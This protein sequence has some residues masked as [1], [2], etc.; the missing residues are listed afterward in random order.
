MLGWLL[1]TG[2]YTSLLRVVA[3]VVT[4]GFVA[5]MSHWMPAADFGLLAM[6][7][8][9]CTLAAAVGAF[10]QPQLIVRDASSFIADGDLEQGHQI[11]R[12]ALWRSMI[13][14]LPVGVAVMLFF[15]VYSGQIGFAIAAGLV[16]IGLAQLL[17]WAAVARSHEKYLWSLGPKD[18]FWRLGILGL[19]GV[20]VLTG[21]VPDIGIVS[22]FAVMVLLLLLG[23]QR[24]VFKLGQTQAVDQRQKHTLWGTSAA[25][26]TSNLSNVA[27]NT[28]DVVLVGVFLTE[29]AA[30]QYFPANRLALLAGFFVLP[31]TMVISPRFARQAKVNNFDAMQRLNSM[32]TLFVTTGAMIVTGILL[33]LYDIYAPLFATAG[34]D[35]YR[36]LQIL[37]LG[38]LVLAALGFPSVV[39]NLTG[40][41]YRQAR[42]NVLFLIGFVIAFCGVGLLGLGIVA[43][44]YVAAGSLILRKLVLAGVAY[45]HVGISPLSLPKK[46]SK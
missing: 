17:A 6:M 40:H 29:L 11:C 3:M 42:I 33:G 7:M 12:V 34:P 24:H 5:L 14:S 43:F 20:I 45:V 46:G 25:F 1:K 44:A 26:M 27:Q 30:A 31:L 35:T 9:G 13:V 21:N 22:G 10:G 16:A 32:A 41:Q 18:I 28:L 15:W 36:A 19:T 37:L 38:Q 8:S 2:A 4:L 39:L 23:L